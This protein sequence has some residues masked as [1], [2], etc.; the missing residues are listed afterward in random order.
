L[1]FPVD[2]EIEM[3]LAIEVIAI[4]IGVESLAPNDARVE[5][6]LDLRHDTK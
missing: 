3:D 2:D 6:K 1:H 5:T 4:S